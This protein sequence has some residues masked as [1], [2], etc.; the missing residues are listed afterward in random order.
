MASIL[1]VDTVTGVT[2]TNYTKLPSGVA[3]GVTITFITV[4][5]N[6]VLA[7]ANGGIQLSHLS[8]AVLQQ[9]TAQS[10]VA[11]PATIIQKV[12]KSQPPGTLAC[13]GQAVSRTNYSA[14]FAEIGTTFGTGDGS[15]TFNVPNYGGSFYI[16]Y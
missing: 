10:S 4:A 16:K 1:S 2:N 12:G 14:L 15:T 6:S 5:N 3:D 7:L 8:P 9:V 13:T 11:L